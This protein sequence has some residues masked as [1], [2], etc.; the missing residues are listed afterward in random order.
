MWTNFLQHERF[1]SGV[2][3]LYIV[4]QSKIN[5]FCDLESDINTEVLLANVRYR[6]LSAPLRSTDYKNEEGP[7]CYAAPSK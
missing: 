3:T 6:L 4:R 7:N 2:N 5:V 1:R